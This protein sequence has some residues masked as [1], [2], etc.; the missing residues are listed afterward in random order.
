MFL[1]YLSCSVWMYYNAK[2]LSFLLWLLR[3]SKFRNVWLFSN[4]TREEKSVKLGVQYMHSECPISA[5]CHCLFCNHPWG[6]QR[7]PLLWAFLSLSIPTQFSW[8]WS[9]DKKTKVLKTLQSEQYILRLIWS[10]NHGEDKRYCNYCYHYPKV[11]K[12]KG[13]IIY[14]F[15]NAFIQFNNYKCCIH[16]KWSIICCH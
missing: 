12:L 16:W 1:G 5:K 10:F 6:K 8:K 13:S 7:M 11:V 2:F 15:G 9:I 14:F 4:R 3:F